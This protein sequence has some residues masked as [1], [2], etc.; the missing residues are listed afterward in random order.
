M[1]GTKSYTTC[2]NRTGRLAF[3]MSHHL[4][5]ATSVNFGCA[6]LI[7]KCS[8]FIPRSRLFYNQTI[9]HD[10]SRTTTPWHNLGFLRQFSI[11]WFLSLQYLHGGPL[12]ISC[13]RLLVCGLDSQ[14]LYGLFVLIINLWHR[15]IFLPPFPPL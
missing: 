10:M 9:Y 1:N 12:Y 6:F 7:G 3:L 4:Y 11:Q 14:P 15:L 5:F 13:S 2:D 8:G